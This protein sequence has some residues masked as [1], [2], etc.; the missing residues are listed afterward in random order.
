MKLDLPNGKSVS[1]HVQLRDMEMCEQILRQIEAE[2]EEK[3]WDEPPTYLL[4]NRRGEGDAQMVAVKEITWL[5]PMVYHD[6][7]P[8]LLRLAQ[9]FMLDDPIANFLRDA[10]PRLVGGETFYGLVAFT[11]AWM[12]SQPRDPGDPAPTLGPNY[13][14]PGDMVPPREH[15][16]RIEIRS[17]VM[18]TVDGRVLMLVRKRGEFPEFYELNEGDG[19]IETGGR[20]VDALR[21]LCT[22]FHDAAKSA[23]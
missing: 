1:V 18:V 11:E 10:I 9:T 21:M 7:G 8:G 3:G 15:P 23:G 6:P 19:P 13:E 2:L 16:D 20:V 4:L 5:P 12:I 22:T 14:L 17:G